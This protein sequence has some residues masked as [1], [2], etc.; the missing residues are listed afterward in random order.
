MG[1]D[2]KNM[3][4]FRLS[5]RGY[6]RQDVNRYIEE[7]SLRFTASENALR[8][9][10]KEL[11]ARLSGEDC[12]KSPVAEKLTAENRALR[13]ENR[14]LAEENSRLSEDCRPEDSAEYREISEKLGDIILKANLDADRVKNEAEAEAEKLMSEASE[15]ADAVRL[16]SAVDA[17]VLLSNVRTSLGDLTE[18]Q[19]SA[20]KTVSKDTVSEYEKLYK[21][22]EERFDAMGKLTL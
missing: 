7:M 14:R 11:E 2:E 13:E 10:I 5:R 9:R 22:L 6:D 15:R 16:K 1:N 18:K 8:S 3:V 17:R 4:A 21:E 19:L 20:L 12:E